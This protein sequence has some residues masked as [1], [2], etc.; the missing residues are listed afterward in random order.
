MM[1]HTQQY[2]IKNKEQEFMPLLKELFN[3]FSYKIL[4]STIDEPKTVFQIC[5]ENDI[6]VS[7]TYKK[8]R[9]LKDSGILSID[10]IV[11][12]EKGKKVVFYKSKIQSIE[13]MLNNQGVIWQL[14]KNE[15]NPHVKDVKDMQETSKQM[16]T[17]H[18]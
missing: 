3:G 15:K 8:I 11:I 6:A 5:N 14:K 2:E 1:R 18:Y 10:K 17:T 9:R 12:N 16:E 13:L 7:S 4:L